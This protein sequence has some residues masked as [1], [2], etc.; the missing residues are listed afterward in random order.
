MSSFGHW[1]SLHCPNR[2]SINMSA[3]NNGT[4]E[5][6]S[7]V[8][9]DSRFSNTLIGIEMGRGSLPS[10]PT[11]NSLILENV[12]FIN[13]PTAIQG[14]DS[15]VLAGSVNHVDAWGQGNSYSS[16][17]SEGAFQ[18]LITP[19][20]RPASLTSGRNFYDKSKPYYGNIK[21][22]G[23]VSAQKQGAVG[24]GVTDDTEALNDIFQ[25][26][27]SSGKIVYL[28]AGHYLVTKTIHVPPGVKIFGEAVSNTPLPFNPNSPKAYSSI[29]SSSQAAPSSPQSQ[30]Q[31]PSSKSATAP[32]PAQSK[33]QT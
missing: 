15:I 10:P 24:D 25:D 4:L 9:I 7:M 18:G 2:A 16:S 32:N 12:D 27:A 20:V 31:N 8:I 5:V 28:N 14:P 3:T 33:S 21:A 13:V 6:G 19:N 30:T 1:N 11:G 17:G 26:A 22:S 23:F 29:P